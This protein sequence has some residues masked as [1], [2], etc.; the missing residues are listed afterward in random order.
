MVALAAVYAC[1]GC[2]RRRVAAGPWLERFGR[3][4][5]FVY[6]IHVELVYGY[7]TLADAWD[8]C[9]SGGQRGRIRGLHRP[10]CTGPSSCAIG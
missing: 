1:R 3:S 8:G 7:A 5:L 10:A 6:W 4:S 2:S 9:P